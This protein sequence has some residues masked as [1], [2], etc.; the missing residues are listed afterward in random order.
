MSAKKKVKSENESCFIIFR[1][2]VKFL[3]S[4]RKILSVSLFD[5]LKKWLL[6]FGN[7]GF[8][9]ASGL[10][11][12]IGII[13]AIRLNS[14]GIFATAFAYALGFFILQF[15]A[16]KFANA[17]DKLI[18]NNRTSL[19]SSAF[20]DSIGLLTMIGGALIFL[21]YTYLAIKVG[22]F[23][24]FIQ[25][26][27]AFIFFELV[28]LL[29]L[30][31]GSITVEIGEDTS[32]GQEAIGIVTFFLKIFMKLIPVIFGL[33]III[34]TI[35]MFIHSFGLFKEGFGRSFAW[36]RVESDMVSIAGAALFPLIG[37]II[38]VFVFLTIDVVRAILSI[39]K[40]LDKLAK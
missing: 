23:A 39:P 27:A 4:M 25:G 31:P 28:A 1:F 35:L 29:S 20:P 16:V 30:N 13:A 5:F 6:I 14:F 18:S 37:Y 24:P 10:A 22:V 19:A 40:K 7:C 11:L 36:M 3:E 32:A 34:G 2:V 38:F 26:L 9:F 8:Y 12:L 33:G 21:Y 15:V 17:G